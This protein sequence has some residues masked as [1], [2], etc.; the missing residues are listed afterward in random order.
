[1]NYM[2]ELTAYPFSTIGK[3]QNNEDAFYP[4]IPPATTNIFI[5]CDGVGGNNSG[6]TAANITAQTMGE[7]IKQLDSTNVVTALQ[8]VTIALQEYVVANPS[9]AAM[10][11]TLVLAACKNDEVLVAWCGDSRLYHIR[12]GQVLYKTTDHSLVQ[13]IVSSGLITEQKALGHSKKNIILRSVHAKMD[14][15]DLEIFTLPNFEQ[16]DYLLLCTDGLLEVLTPTFIQQYFASQNTI[17]NLQQQLIQL[18]YNN[19]NDNCTWYLIQ[20]K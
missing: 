15:N 16:T 20:K 5:V 3:R 11:T 17:E 14:I 2:Q 19:T 8:Q 4:P 18:A 6:E 1:M 10:A 13:Q 9:S 7:N 12:N